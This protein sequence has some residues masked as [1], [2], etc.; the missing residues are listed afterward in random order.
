MEYL[1]F[2]IGLALVVLAWQLPARN[3]VFVIHVRNGVP[4]TARGKVG[5]SFLAD[6]ADIVERQRIRRGSIFG[7][8]RH[9]KINLGFSR[10]IPVNCRQSLRNIWSMHAR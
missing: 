5:Q 8:T 4:S 3:R 10:T 1:P 7:L 6:V 2:V 9:G